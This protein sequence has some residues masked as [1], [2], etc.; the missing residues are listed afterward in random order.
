MN[1]GSLFTWYALKNEFWCNSY[2][3][4]PRPENRGDVHVS[5]YEGKYNLSTRF[6]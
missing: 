4:V 2:T 3:C 1:I 5:C 6:S